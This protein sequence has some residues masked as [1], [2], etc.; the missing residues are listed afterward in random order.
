MKFNKL[1]LIVL[2]FCASIYSQE[3]KSSC[4]EFEETFQ[5]FQITIFIEN[6]EPL[7]I[8]VVGKDINFDDFSKETLSGF[9]NDLYDKHNFMPSFIT[10]RNFYLKGCNIASIDKISDL[11]FVSKFNGKFEKLS[12]KYKKYYELKTGE[13][14][15][16]QG[17][18]IEGSFL[19][20]K[21][22]EL[23]FEKISFYPDEIYNCS[24]IE[25]Y[26]IPIQISSF[27]KL[28]NCKKNKR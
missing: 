8:N 15:T 9:I 19:R 18:V 7:L 20:F 27:Y 16:V 14:I 12:K 24:K 13:K 1:Y 21:K 4:Q 5:Y 11:I 3:R 22:D 6:V 26:L 17:I 10:D 2:F 28:N 23:K 25:N